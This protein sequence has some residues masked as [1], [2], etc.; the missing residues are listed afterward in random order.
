MLSEQAKRNAIAAQEYG[1]RI[2]EEARG[3]Y[4]TWL[5]N[6]HGRVSD[7]RYWIEEAAIEQ[8]NAAEQYIIQRYC[9]DYDE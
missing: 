4:Q 5:D 6:P 3:L 9:R 7:R 8:K 2:A 1:A